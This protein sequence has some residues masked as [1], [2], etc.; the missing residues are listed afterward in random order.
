MKNAETWS[1][2]ALKSPDTAKSRLRALL[3][4]TER[5]ALYF[6]MVRKVLGALRATPGIDRVFVV[7]ACDEVDRFA[8]RLGVEV[9][10]EAQETGTAAAFARAIDALAHMGRPARLLMIAGDLP[11][12]T[13]AALS[14]L[15]NQ[16]L[17]TGGVCIV[18]D[19][20]R[21]GTNALLCSPWDAVLPCFGADSF[22]RHLAAARTKDIA[23][24]VFESESLS[25]DIDVVDDLILLSRLSSFSPGKALG[26]LLASL[27][28]ASRPIVQESAHDTHAN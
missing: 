20:K 23:V 11:L 15:V 28:P 7:T 21:S 24:Q 5:R 14:P 10:R 25:L 19:R 26:N 12:I 4:E 22:R 13:P 6:F 8:I 2:V 17:V 3:S 9:I 16:S 27:R 1:V 18:P